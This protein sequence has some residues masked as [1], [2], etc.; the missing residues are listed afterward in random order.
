[1]KTYANET[2]KLL[3]NRASCRSFE[4]KPIEDD[5]LNEVIDAGLH[6]ATG[7]N[8]QPFSIIKIASETN[9]NWLVDECKMQNLVRNAAV[10][11][12]FLIDWKRT[13]KWAK[14]LNAPYVAIDSY[15]HF[16]IA[17]QDTV[18]CAQNI[19]TAADAMGLG[20]VYIGAVESC[21]MELKEKFEIPNGVFP[22]V[23]LSMGY[24]KKYPA[25]APKLGIETVVHEEKYIERS[26]EELIA[27]YDKKYGGKTHKITEERLETIYQVIQE[28]DG[29]VRAETIVDDIKKTGYFNMAQFYFGLKYKADWS[30]A[31][32]DSFVET[33]KQCGFSWITG[34]NIPNKI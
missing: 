20:S 30:A 19:C 25:P 17:F 28:V 11:L 21:F 10:N 29:K 16:W 31:D 9:K 18:I 14:A 26:D 7:G 4:K 27:A 34:E 23:L 3:F 2:M 5:V 32:N 24:P 33:L 1:M 15:R 12:L 22:V 8:L 6:A 13:E